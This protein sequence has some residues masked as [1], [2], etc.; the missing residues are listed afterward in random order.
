[1]KVSLALSTA[2]H[3]SSESYLN[4]FRERTVAFGFIPSHFF[5]QSLLLGFPL[6]LHC[7]PQPA[8]FLSIKEVVDVVLFLLIAFQVASEAENLLFLLDKEAFLKFLCNFN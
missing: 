7:C 5:L 1:M 3:L 6:P 2:L 8:T 4:Q